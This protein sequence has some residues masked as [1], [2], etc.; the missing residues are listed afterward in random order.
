MP[1]CS[2]AADSSATIRQKKPTAEKPPM[3]RTTPPK[4]APPTL[5][6]WLMVPSIPMAVTREFPDISVPMATNVG[7]PILINVIPTS[8]TP[9]VPQAIISTEKNSRAPSPPMSVHTATVRPR[10]F[11]AATEPAIVLPSTTPIPTIASGMAMS[12]SIAYCP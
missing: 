10:R 7:H 2:T 8:A 4:A 5:P 3:A 6:N 1:I 12:S 9:T 11:I